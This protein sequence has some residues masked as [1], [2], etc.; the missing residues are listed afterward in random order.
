MLALTARLTTIGN[1]RAT[2][3]VLLTKAP[4][5]EVTNITSKNNFNS[6]LPANF[7]MC[8]LIILAS[9]VWKIAPPT[10]NSP[11]IIMTTELEN[12]DKASSGVNI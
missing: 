10:T 7:R 9:P 2:V 4:M 11:T 12:P 1:I 8:E 3:P 5:A 6:L